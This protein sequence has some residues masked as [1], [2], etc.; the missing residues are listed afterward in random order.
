MRREIARG[1]RRV[2]ERHLPSH[3]SAQARSAEKESQELRDLGVGAGCVPD[4]LALLRS[5]GAQDTQPE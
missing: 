5:D 3:E 4:G 1:G 2:K